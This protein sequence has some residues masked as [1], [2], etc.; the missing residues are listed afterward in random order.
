MMALVILR[1]KAPKTVLSLGSTPC[2][3][4]PTCKA[5]AYPCA[6]KSASSWSHDTPCPSATLHS[7][8]M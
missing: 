1:L 5:A 4:G 3:S 7:C 2:L 8:C 6:Q